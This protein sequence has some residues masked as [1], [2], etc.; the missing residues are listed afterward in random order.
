M[1]KA[2]RDYTKER[3]AGG[4]KK[5]AKTRARWHARAKAIKEGRAKVGDGK[6]V[7]HKNMNPTDNR[8]S[9]LR[10]ISA[11]ANMKKQPKR[12]RSSTNRKK[13]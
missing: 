11:K 3:L 4:E 8:N 6:H 13:T 1:T 7:D 5:K 2:K 12:G 9:N 10:V